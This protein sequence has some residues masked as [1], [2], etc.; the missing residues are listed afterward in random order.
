[1]NN[2][3][4]LT[5]KELDSFLQIY[6]NGSVQLKAA[7]RYAAHLKEHTRRNTITISKAELR[8][9]LNKVD[10]MDD[11]LNLVLLNPDELIALLFPRTI[12]NPTEED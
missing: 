5:D 11:D 3:K 12:D 4:E 2:E 9:A 1:M 8:T 7:I 6:S 10:R